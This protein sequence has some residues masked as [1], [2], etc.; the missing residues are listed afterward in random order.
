MSKRVK[1][2]SE[3]LQHELAA[4]LKKDT[5]DPRFSKV[6]ITEVDV[7]PDLRNATVYITVLESDAEEAV[8]ALTGAKGYLKNLIGK[9]LSLRFLP[10]LIFKEDKSL[11]HADKI[12]K[13][14]KK[15]QDK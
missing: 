11:S 2:V 5:S 13:I 3:T 9:D 4:I 6:T 12:D 14:I 8:T 15:L 1:R 10:E 7:S